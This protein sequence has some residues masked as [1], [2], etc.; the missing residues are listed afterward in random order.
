MTDNVMNKFEM[1]EYLNGLMKYG[2]WPHR[3]AVGYKIKTTYGQYF[4]TN[5]LTTNRGWEFLQKF[6]ITS[7]LYVLKETSVLPSS[8]NPMVPINILSDCKWFCRESLNPGK[9][10][11]LVSLRSKAKKEKKQIKSRKIFIPQKKN[12]R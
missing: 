12:W 11:Y 5:C 8:H 1:V 9:R 10:K 7:D 6:W 2:S 3:L 4:M